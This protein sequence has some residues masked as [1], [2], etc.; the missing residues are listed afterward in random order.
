MAA[1]AVEAEVRRKFQLEEVSVVPSELV[2]ASIDDAHGEVMARLS[3]IVDTGAPS[4]GLVLG[5]T[6]L[7]G[8]HLLTSMASKDAAD[9]KDLSLGG[10]RIGTGDRFASLLAMASKAEARAWLTLAP[11]L[12]AV[13][14]EA[15]GNVT[16]TVAVLGTEQ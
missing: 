7:A 11:Y 3:P 5:E 10:Q 2:Q 4:A 8:A 1:F 15:A 14:G 13:P 9:Q 16:D 12:A 6:L